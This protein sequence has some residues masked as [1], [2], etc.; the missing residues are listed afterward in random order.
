M[1]AEDVQGKTGR[2]RSRGLRAAGVAAMVLIVM[3]VLSLWWV[4]H[5]LYASPFIPTE[6]TQGE[7]QALEVKLDRL[8]QSSMDPARTGGSDRGRLQPEPYREDDAKRTIVLSERELNALIARDEETARRVALDL[9]KDMLSVR[10]LIPVDRDFPVLGGKTIRLNCG[11][12]LGYEAGRPVVAV[13][14]VSIGGVPIP[15]AWLGNIKEIDLIREF[16]GQGGFWDLFSAGVED[17][18]VSDGSLFIRL[19]E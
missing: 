16:G 7:R 12:R 17:L 8:E 11:I 15:N 13:R 2:G 14:G 6:L 18:R 3:A 19:K 10:L 5:N 9:S 1:P 4:R